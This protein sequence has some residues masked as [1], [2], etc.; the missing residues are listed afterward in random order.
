MDLHA[1]IKCACQFRLEHEQDQ[2]EAMGFMLQG[3]KTFQNH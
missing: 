2:D 1:C 3:I